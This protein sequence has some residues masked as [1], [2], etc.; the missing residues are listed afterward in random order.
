M[1][2]L[3]YGDTYIPNDSLK[4]GVVPGKIGTHIGLKAGDKIIAVGGKE[5]IRFE[6]LLS[7]KVLLGNT[8][9]TVIRDGKQISIAVPGSILNDVSDY[10]ENEFVT[11]RTKYDVDTVKKSSFAAQAGLLHGDSIVAVNKVP[12]PFLDQLHNELD[13]YKGKYVN[14]LVKRKTDTMT[15][16]TLVNSKGM[17]G[18]PDGKNGVVLGIN[19]I[20][21]VTEKYNFAKALPVGASRAWGMFS[22]NAKGLGKVVNG[23]LKFNKAVSGPVAMA[24]MFGRHFDWFRFW[25]MVGLLSMALA[26]MNLLPIPALDGGHALFL[27]IEM[28]KGKP[29]SDKFLERA[30]LVG[31]VILIC[32]MV[33]VFGNDIVRHVIKK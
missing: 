26:L 15:L 10:K 11:P 8:Q 7:S 22:A 17:L 4:Y 14:L 29:L 30:Q 1:L 19:D 3:R 21:E 25:S 32:L 28:I 24:T 2:A 20:K 27:I 12:V 18:F 13:K 31:F 9:L 6:E 23:E 33:F 16:H 5:I